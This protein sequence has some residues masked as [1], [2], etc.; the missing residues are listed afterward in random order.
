[1][2]TREDNVEH[3]EKIAEYLNPPGVGFQNY[4]SMQTRRKK[5]NAV[6]G[7]MRKELYQRLRSTLQQK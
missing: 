6:I 3:E 2:W 7:T 5:N 4:T 1:M